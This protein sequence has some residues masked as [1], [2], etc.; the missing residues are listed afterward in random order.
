M[1]FPW[2]NEHGKPVR[3]SPLPLNISTNLLQSLLESRPIILDNNRPNLHCLFITLWLD[4]LS[5]DF[6]STFRTAPQWF[7]GV[8][9]IF[10]LLW[11]P[12]F[13]SEMRI[14][15]PWKFSCI[16]LKS[17]ALRCHKLKR[18]CERE[19]GYRVFFTLS[20]L[21]VFFEGSLLFEKSKDG[22]LLKRRTLSLC[23][24]NH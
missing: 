3:S 8:E 5:F 22:I 1:L 20:R 19:D 21:S 7:D 10:L 4:I 11:V 17:N 9:T 6:V 15:P 13:L 12:I 23:L 14:F 24:A 18:E 16:F 2:E